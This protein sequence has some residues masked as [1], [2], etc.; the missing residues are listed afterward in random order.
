MRTEE[1]NEMAHTAKL[2]SDKMRLFE[3]KFDCDC[4]LNEVNMATGIFN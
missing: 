4:L 3:I 2:N 1:I